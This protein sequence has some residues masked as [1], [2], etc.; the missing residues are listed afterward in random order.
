MIKLSAFFSLK[1]LPLKSVLQPILLQY[2]QDWKGNTNP[3]RTKKKR[4]KERK[5]DDQY[6]QVPQENT[7]YLCAYSIDLGETHNECLHCESVGVHTHLCY[8]MRKGKWMWSIH[9]YKYLSLILIELINKQY[10]LIITCRYSSKG[11]SMLLYN[12]WAI[13][14][15]SYFDV[16]KW[17]LID[18]TSQ[19]ACQQLVAFQRAWF[20]Y[21]QL[22]HIYK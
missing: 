15:K 3:I 8:I 21:T 12:A 13:V 22:T 19:K 14:V 18:K 20:G 4:K 1:L 5:I 11:T 17:L 2:L 7:E 9:T 10:I 16:S 6:L